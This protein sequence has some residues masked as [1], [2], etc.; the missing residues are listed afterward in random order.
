M[1]GFTNNTL[2]AKAVSTI[3]IKR[4]AAGKKLTNGNNGITRQSPPAK[5]MV[6]QSSG[7]VKGAMSGTGSNRG[8]VSKPSM[9]C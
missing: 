4:G 9:A 8:S 1:R 7:G 6:G 5:N 3:H 2:R